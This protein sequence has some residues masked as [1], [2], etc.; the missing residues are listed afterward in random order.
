MPVCID[1]TIAELRQ[2][3]RQA[4]C[5]FALGLIGG[6]AF[7]KF[8]APL[9]WVLG[10]MAVSLV[11]SLAGVRLWLPPWLK[12]PAFLIL[13]AMFG[14]SITLG[15]FASSAAWIVTM[16]G[17]IIF[18]ATTMPAA[19]IYLRRA[20][21]FDSTTAFFASAPGGLLPMSALGA[22][23]GGDERRI[24]LIQSMRMVLTIIAIPVA[25]RLFGG[26]DPQG[27]TLT[28][29]TLSDLNEIDWFTLVTAALAGFGI[30]RLLRI[31]S[32]QVLGPLIAVLLV[33]Q[34]TG[35]VAKVPDPLSA[36]AQLI[37]GINVGA[38]FSGVRLRTV[39]QIL[40]HGLVVGAIM[41]VTAVIMALA[42]TTITEFGFPALML[43]YGPGGMAEMT[44]V[45]MAVGV[46][47]AFILGHQLGRFLFIMTFAPFL[48]RRW[49]GISE[50]SV[51]V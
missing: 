40:S 30:A 36:A 44:L 23:L 10:P 16:F 51:N 15:A 2:R 25:F 41:L 32:P 48:Y 1:L 5:L 38:G 29:I 49:R 37:I 46:D 18:V 26:Y 13:G 17:T 28:G 24:V 9:P 21:G 50:D 45:G 47:V 3:W 35:L 39:A 34:F 31:P 8:N 7:V 14:A 19:T 22:T 6:F 27:S 11:A 42:M 12:L 43:A 33:N 4:V 20:G